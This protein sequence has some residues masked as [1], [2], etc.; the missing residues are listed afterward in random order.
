MANSN[1]N[2]VDLEIKIDERQFKRQLSAMESLAK[3]T[4]AEISRAF[5]ELRLVDFGKSAAQFAADL[6]KIQ[7]A[8][9]IEKSVLTSARKI[10]GQLNNLSGIDKLNVIHTRKNDNDSSGSIHIENWEKAQEIISKIANDFQQMID[11]SMEISFDFNLEELKLEFSLALG[12]LSNE[13]K[14]VIEE[15]NLNLD[16]TLAKFN[17]NFNAVVAGILANL[18]AVLGEI[19]ADFVADFDAAAEISNEMC[20]K[21]EQTMANISFYINAAITAMSNNFLAIVAVVSTKLVAGFQA[22]ADLCNSMKLNLGLEQI[23]VTMLAL[24]DQLSAGLTAIIT[25]LYTGLEALQRVTGKVIAIELQVNLAPLYHIYTMFQYKPLLVD[26]QLNVLPI[27]IDQ[28]L[29]L[30]SQTVINF[31]LS[32]LIHFE[33]GD[34]FSFEKIFN[35]EEFLTFENIFDIGALFNFENFEINLELFKLSLGEIL[36]FFISKWGELGGFMSNIWGGIQQIFEPVGTW[37]TEKFSSAFGGIQSTFSS[38]GE[39]FA[40]KWLSIQEGLGGIPEWFGS[41][42][43]QASDGTKLPFDGIGEFFGGVWEGIKEKFT[44]ITDWFREKFSTAWE[45]VKG[46]FDSDGETFGKIKE[47]I[48]DTFKTVVNFLISGLNSIIAVPFN[49][50]NK[51]LNKLRGTNVLGVKPFAGLWDENPIQVPQI[52]K[53]AQGGYVRANTPQLAMIGDNRHY[54]EIVAPENKMNE[55]LQNAVSA[56]KSGLELTEMN[57]LLRELV[58][59]TK[60]ISKKDLVAAISASELFGAVKQENDNYKRVTG[61]SLL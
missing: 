4:G 11:N 14:L 35:F 1:A 40:G 58:A 30:S 31:N 52:P 23:K 60:A 56:G 2:T 47:G 37:F 10:I 19:G 57:M 25:Q 27:S 34:L 48:G 54:G 24:L 17:V 15:L 8:A 55:L 12:D 20:L 36:D 41:L 22:I 61:L 59:I 46:V 49:K 26:C 33:F 6:K 39:F 5:S 42:F 43:G 21:L 45:A 28:A 18:Q 7:K 13:F 32:D 16:L 53:L 50:M 38:I 44:P 29:D 9:N 51:T 3:K